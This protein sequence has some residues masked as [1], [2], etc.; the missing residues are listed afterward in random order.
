LATDEGRAATR[1]FLDEAADLVIR[2]GGSL[3][4]EHGDGQARAELL[5]KM[6]GPELVQA[7][8]E[9]KAAWDP[10][11]RMNPG[12]IVD[13]HGILDDLRVGENFKPKEPATHFRYPKQEN[14]FVRA[15]LR[16]VGVGKCRNE[17]GGLMCPS[18]VAT[19]D[20][21]DSTRGRAHLLFE[22]LKGETI[23]DGWK[24]E[25]VREALDLCLSCKGCKS[26]CPTNV[27]M[28]TYK[29]EFLSHYY[30]G[31]LRPRHAYAFGFVHRWLKIGSRA[32]A[33]ANFFT[34]TPGFSHLAKWLA[35]VAPQRRIPRLARQTFRRWMSGRHPG[36]SRGPEQIR[37]GSGFR[38]NDGVLQVILWADTF[39]NYLKPEVGK[40]A[41][42]VLEYLGYQ[43]VL[44]PS[45]LCC[46]R[47]LYDYGFLDQAKVQLRQILTAL[48]V[49]V[50][51][52]MPVIVLEPSCAAVFKDELVNL[53][54]EDPLAEKL[55]RQTFLLSEFLFHRIPSIDVTP[56]KVGAQNIDWVPAFAGMTTKKA[57]LQ[58][59][60]HQKSVLSASADRSLLE[61]LGFE[62][63][64]PEPGCCGMAG[65]FGFEKG[66][67]PIAKQIAERA[68]LPAVRS[69]P[70]D[71]LIVADGFS[72]REQIAQS[73]NRKALHIAQILR[74]SL[75][76]TPS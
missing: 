17:E 55:C 27:D 72:C 10:Q 13:P 61:K 26:D 34:Q 25:E 44:P 51:S 23:K 48:K 29:A 18:Y 50:E 35:G 64:E 42:E 73:T 57:I 69:A 54:P 38:R 2:Y 5:P 43:V 41:V 68:L 9:F 22:M 59:H 39:T 20:E 31:R 15:V 66:H 62:I 46:G 21:K 67:A 49:P 47:P 30:A 33:L 58:T 53:F 24:S 1:R 12:K 28:A 36:G 16:C 8:R 45:G 70:P 6:F 76:G 37:L 32:P 71:A 60:C 52:G 63:Q 40:A 7:F 19:R 65:S 75:R 4:G 74:R 3:S 11:G 14:S 56:T